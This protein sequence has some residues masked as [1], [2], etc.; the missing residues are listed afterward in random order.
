VASGDSSNNGHR[1]L[2]GG[3]SRFVVVLE[4]DV[5][6]SRRDPSFDPLTAWRELFENH[7]GVVAACAMAD[8]GDWAWALEDV[9]PPIAAGVRCV[10]RVATHLVA[11]DRR[12]F[13]PATTRFGAF[14]LDIFVDREDLSYNWEDL[15]SHVGTTGGRRIAWPE[16]WPL[17]V[18]HCDRKVAPGSMHN[19]QD[20]RVK[21]AVLDH[22]QRN[23]R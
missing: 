16:G 9:G 3:R 20:T 19:T 22:L 21:L 6:V 4:D 10:N 2:L 17:R 8:A 5:L 13:L 1:R 11:Y 15:V 14:D 12:R 18:Y 7:A 23:A